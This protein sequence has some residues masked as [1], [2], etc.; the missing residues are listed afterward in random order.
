MDEMTLLRNVVHEAPLPTATDV[1][2]ARQ[3]LMA[4]LAA[5]QPRKSRKRLILSGATVVGLAAAITGVVAFGGLES[6]GVA[7]P[8]A[9][10]VAF[11]RRRPRTPRHP[12]TARP[13]RLYPQ[14]NDRWRPRGLA[15]GRR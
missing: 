4:G 15:L 11:L 12:A 5:E 2:P 3:R 7:P 14:R 6:V 1:A 9:E 10:A 8:E 13:V